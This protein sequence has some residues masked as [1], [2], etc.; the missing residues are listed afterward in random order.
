MAVALAALASS[1]ETMVVV[2]IAVELDTQ[3]DA[4]ILRLV[5]IVVC[6]A[7]RIGE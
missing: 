2:D 1:V 4:H 7:G 5:R 6:A 3:L